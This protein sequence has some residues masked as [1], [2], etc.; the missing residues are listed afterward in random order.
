MTTEEMK[1]AINHMVDIC[2]TR[3]KNA[4]WHDSP[5]EVGTI[6]ML[7]VSEISEAMEGARKDLMDDHLPHRKMME[8]ELADGIIRIFDAAGFFGMD[9]GGAVMEKLAYNLSRSD[10]KRENRQKEGGKKF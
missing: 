3:S 6:L 2:Y 9:L 8:V 4:G 7:I 10:H 1:N 5:R